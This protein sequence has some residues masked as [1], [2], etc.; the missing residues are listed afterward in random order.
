MKVQ[1][2]AIGSFTHTESLPYLNQ[3]LFAAKEAGIE[4]KQIIT[5]SINQT[6][7]KTHDTKFFPPKGSPSLQATF[8]TP[9]Q[10]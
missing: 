3:I 7:K 10:L 2:W 8:C 5:K 4:N 6:N 1:S 9:P